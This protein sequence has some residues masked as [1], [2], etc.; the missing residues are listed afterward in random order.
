[1][2][3]QEQNQWCWAA[4]AV[5]VNW[6][7]DSHSNW[8][9]CIMANFEFDQTTCCK[10]GSTTACNRPHYLSTAM[11]D[12]GNLADG[13]PISGAAS[14]DSITNEINNCQPVGM[15]FSWEKTVDHSVKGAHAV[16]IAGYGEGILYL[17]DPAGPI[18]N[19]FDYDDLT[20]GECPYYELTITSW[21]ET[22]FSR[23]SPY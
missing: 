4:V 8:T 15:A 11:Y 16:A 12:T 13:S 20:S 1:M 21:D 23:R 17:E 18:S 9:Q 2:Q 6:Y 22:D 3:N 5:S 7:Y 10:D 19:Y 14:Y